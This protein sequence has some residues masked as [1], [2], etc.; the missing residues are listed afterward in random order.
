M[1]SIQDIDIN[2]DREYRE[3]QARINLS[4]EAQ[5]IINTE[6]GQYDS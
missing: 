6:G 5:R 3:A 4:H 1:Q 2:E